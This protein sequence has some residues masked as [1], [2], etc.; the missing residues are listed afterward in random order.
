METTE[1]D[2]VK[3]EQAS[4]P[5]NWRRPHYDVSESDDAFDVQVHLPG[6]ERSGIDIS[7][8]DDNLTVI[9][10]R[11]E[12]NTQDWRPIRQELPQGDFRLDLRLNV[13]V[14]ESKIRAQIENGVLNLQ[15]PKK[16]K[17]K[18]RK[19]KIS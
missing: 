10:T 11:A 12:F 2:T 7:I 18:P 1:L 15:F 8:K 13:P 14:K 9:G 17:I 5:Q 4:K 3:N 19:I 16:E 6:V